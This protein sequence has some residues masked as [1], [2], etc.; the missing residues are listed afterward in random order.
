MTGRQDA[1]VLVERRGRILLVTLNR[2]SA[3]NAIDGAVA[4]ELA[5]AARELDSDPELSV[6][7]LTGTGQDFC[8]GMDLKAFAR[9]EDMSPVVRFIREG[10]RKPLI[11]AVEGHAV[12]GGLELVLACDLVVAASDARMGIPEATVGL[13]AAGGGLLR[14]PDRIGSSLAL[15]MALTGDPVSAERAYAAGFLARLAE[16]GEAEQEA[17]RLAERVAHNAPLGIAA[18][19]E[20]IRAGRGMTEAQFWAYQ[21]PLRDQVFTSGDAREGPRAFAEKRPPRWTGT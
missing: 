14:L 7:V 20:L 2:P 18:S 21:A 10:T 1:T 6:G 8:A 13:F 9:K 11:A 19:K 16:P 3:R 17:L 12:A 15:Q 5:A 4:E